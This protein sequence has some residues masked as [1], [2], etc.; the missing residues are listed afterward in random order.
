MYWNNLSIYVLYI[1]GIQSESH[2]MVG[3][4]V[5]GK[6]QCFLNFQVMQRSTVIFCEVHSMHDAAYLWPPSISFI[7]CIHNTCCLIWGVWE[8]PHLPCFHRTCHLFKMMTCM[9][10]IYSPWSSM[11]RRTEPSQSGLCAPRARPFVLLCVL[12][13]KGHELVWGAVMAERALCRGW[14]ATDLKRQPCFLSCA[15]VEFWVWYFIPL[16]A[17]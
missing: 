1:E 9:T 15:C 3:F 16:P 11:I 5:F 12:F 10:L 17:C 4:D 13:H 14:R 8:L 2:L 6:G 7:D